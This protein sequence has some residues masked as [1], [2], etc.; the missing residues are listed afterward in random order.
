MRSVSRLL[1]SGACLIAVSGCI[2]VSQSGAPSAAPA[3]ADLG[4]PTLAAASQTPVSPQPV[5]RQPPSL[6]PSLP[7]ISFPPNS[8]APA[9]PIGGASVVLI[10]DS[11]QDEGTY[12]GSDDPNCSHGAIGED[13]WAAQYGNLL[14]APD[15]L[16]S[17]QLTD[18]PD[19]TD[20]NGRWR[21]VSVYL[22]VGPIFAGRSYTLQWDRFS[23][24]DFTYEINDQGS[25]AVIHVAG[26]T[27]ESPL[28]PGGVG[29]D[30]TVSCPSVS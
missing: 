30:V 25:T 10:I 5:S 14:A 28:G 6:P 12:T 1:I 8:L 22:T 23:S 13:V 20:P 24:D 26:K 2:S 9:T 16:G 18:E 15:E 29:V 19:S 27:I 4:E 11:G 17:L 3:A 21:I 7:P